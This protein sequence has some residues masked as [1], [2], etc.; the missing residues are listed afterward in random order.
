[1]RGSRPRPQ[2]TA[3]KHPHELASHTMPTDIRVPTLGESVT[4]A[5]IGKW[6]KQAGESVAVGEPLLELETDKG[7]REVPAPAGGVLSGISAK[8]G[9]TVAVGAILGHIHEGAGGG[10]AA[11]AKAQAAAAPA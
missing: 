4:E 2:P 3:C 6:F 10:K 7:T 9:E 8:V 5:T 11:P 1:M